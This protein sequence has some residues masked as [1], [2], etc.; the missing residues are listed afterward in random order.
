MFDRGTRTRSKVTLLCRSLA[1]VTSGTWDTPGLSVSTRNRVIPSPASDGGAV[2]QATRHFS[3]AP[4][5]STKVLV[6]LRRK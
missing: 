4:K 3:D 1:R 5:E 6:P 2:R